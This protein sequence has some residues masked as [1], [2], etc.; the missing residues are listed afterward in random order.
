MPEGSSRIPS[1]KLMALRPFVEPQ[2]LQPPFDRVQNDLKTPMEQ[3]PK[4]WKY[5][6][7]R[8]ALMTT[9][10]TMGVVID[11]S[12]LSTWAFIERE[13]S[14]VSRNCLGG[15]KGG[16]FVLIAGL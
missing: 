1:P 5:Q 6:S 10:N 13:A 4:F 12:P 3:L 2:F 16:G 9:A 8:I 14:K 7:C 15:K 11:P